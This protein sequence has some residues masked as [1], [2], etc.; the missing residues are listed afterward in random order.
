MSEE[1]AALRKRQAE[2]LGRITARLRGRWSIDPRSL[3]M[4]M[5]PD[6]KWDVGLDNI[7]QHPGEKAKPATCVVCVSMQCLISRASVRLIMFIT[8][9]RVR[10]VN[11][12]FMRQHSTGYFPLHVNDHAA[13][14]NYLLRKL[15]GVIINEP[16]D[17]RHACEIPPQNAERAND[18]RSALLFFK[19]QQ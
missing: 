9:G 2:I 15:T 6:R 3:S 11:V 7:R 19:R 18:R 10:Q 14:I 5:S 12:V 17:L 16:D 1:M 13:G 8:R 4:S